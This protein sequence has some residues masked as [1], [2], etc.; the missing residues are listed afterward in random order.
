MQSR[1]GVS[2]GTNS[3]FPWTPAYD[4]VFVNHVTTD[5]SSYHAY[6]IGD[7]DAL[8]RYRVPVDRFGEVGRSENG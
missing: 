2:K 6:G 4:F 3:N 1:G 8:F 5:T 7:A